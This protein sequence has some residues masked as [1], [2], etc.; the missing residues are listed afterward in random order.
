MKTEKFIRLAGAFMIAAWIVLGA[1]NLYVGHITRIS[2][3]IMWFMAVWHIFLYYR[4]T[5]KLL[6]TLRD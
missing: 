5:L 1:L 3:G 4:T 2:Y 6:K